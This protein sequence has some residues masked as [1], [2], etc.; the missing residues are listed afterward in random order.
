MSDE[1]CDLCGKLKDGPRHPSG[2]LKRP[3][4][5][6]SAAIDVDGS[7]FTCADELLRA[8]DDEVMIGAEV[9]REAMRAPLLRAALAEALGLL[10]HRVTWSD[11]PADAMRDKIDRAR[12]AELRAKFLGGK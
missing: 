10:E 4:E 9:V 5:A 12:I 11:M 6:C 1:R 2:Y 7:V 3:S 8:P